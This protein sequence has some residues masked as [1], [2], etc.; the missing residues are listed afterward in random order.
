MTQKRAPLAHE[1]SWDIWDM[2]LTTKCGGGTNVPPLLKS[3]SVE[4]FG[5]FFLIDRKKIDNSWKIFGFLKFAVQK[6]LFRQT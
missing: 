5:N 1:I 6:E 2:T 4:L 3:C